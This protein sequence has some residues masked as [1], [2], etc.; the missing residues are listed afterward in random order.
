MPFVDIDIHL[1]QI[2]ILY[3]L[4]DFKNLKN[5]STWFNPCF[6]LRRAF[7]LL[8]MLSQ[9][10]YF[11][12]SQKQT[13]VSTLCASILICLLIAL[14]ILLCVD[15]Y[16]WHIHVESWKKLLKL[17]SSYVL[18]DACYLEFIAL[19]VNSYAKLFYACLESTIHEKF[20]LIWFSCLFIIYLLATIGHCLGSLHSWFVPYITIWSRLCGSMSP[21]KLFCFI[22]Y[23]LEDE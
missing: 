3:S 23:L 5:S 1:S 21:Q 13:R 8:F 18:I 14:I 6:P 19:W 20:L 9:F 16:L 22:V 7:L 11:F 10:T 12:L 2:L 4:Y 17:K 15:N